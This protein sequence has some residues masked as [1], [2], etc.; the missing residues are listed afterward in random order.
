MNLTGD[1]WVPVVFMSGESR[2]VSLR[3]A[4]RSGEEILDLAA[5]PPQRVALTR[6][7]VCT[8]QAALDGP[9]DEAD[10]RSCRNRI[11]SAAVA[12]LEDNC[13]SCHRA[14]SIDR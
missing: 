6:L 14:R 13:R 4:F 12:Y 2:L 8:A 1:P 7:L 3:D 10:W 11:A 9:N 5:T